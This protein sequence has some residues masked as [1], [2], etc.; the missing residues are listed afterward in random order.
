M[1][2]DT[3]AREGREARTG[4]ERRHLTVVFCDR[5]DSTALGHRL[6]PG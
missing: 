5:V 2:P 1:R 4:V 6:D 3:D